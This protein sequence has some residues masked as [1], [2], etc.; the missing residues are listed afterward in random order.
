MGTVCA[1]P[2]SATT[3]Q[4][5]RVLLA[6]FIRYALATFLGYITFDAIYNLF[7]HPLRSFPGPFLGRA[8]NLYA[9]FYT[10]SG[11]QEEAEYALHILYGPFV[12]CQPNQIIIDDPNYIPVVYHMRADKN[13]LPTGE[14]LGLGKSVL[15]A[16]SW[17]QHLRLRKRLVGAYSMGNI[18][19]MEHLIDAHI[20]QFIAQVDE[21][22]AR[23]D[24]TFDFAVWAN[25]YT[26]DVVSELAFGEP[27][28]FV[29]TGSDVASLLEQYHAGIAYAIALAKIPTA[30]KMLAKIPGFHKL[31]VPKPTDKKGFGA[32]M[33]VSS[34]PLYRSPHT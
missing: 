9:F 5:I 22:F 7:L 4:Y 31:I 18:K 17:T 20:I 32:L 34:S 16:A 19:K 11:N 28:G 26:Y 8:S 25:Y 29:R 10:L 24:A 2:S 3:P 14:A 23:N 6:S 21:R 1:D 15:A 30:Q 12:R 27:F 33:G 13:D